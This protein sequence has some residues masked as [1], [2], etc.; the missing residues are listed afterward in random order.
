ME[1]G[2]FGIKYSNRDFTQKEAWGKNQFNT[3]FP[4]AL[5]C[6][7]DSKGLNANYL[8]LNNRLEVE[9]KDIAISKLIGTDVTSEN[10][11]FSFESDFPAYRKYV[12]GN[13]PRVDLVTMDR[14]TAT[15]MR[16]LE[17]KLTALPDNSTC[18]NSEDRYSCEI[19]VRPDSIVYLALSVIAMYENRR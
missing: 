17:V 18:D 9:H 12:V 19:V 7:M 6:Y 13:L 11:F 3:S 15:C 4:A 8:V 1:P 10:L 16:G 5:A 14:S 2:L